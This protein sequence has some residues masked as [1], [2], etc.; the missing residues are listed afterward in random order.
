MFFKCKSPCERYS[1][2]AFALHKWAPA[3]AEP[4]HCCSPPTQVDYL[5][6]RLVLLSE[7]TT[8]TEALLGIEMDHR[9]CVVAGGV[10]RGGVRGCSKQLLPQ[11]CRAAL[12]WKTRRG[13]QRGTCTG[14]CARG[15]V[16]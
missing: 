8:S 12:P 4:H 1:N 2:S 9:R 11:H 3:T 6:R 13:V 15:C 14:V 16:G 10:A 7:R 5:L